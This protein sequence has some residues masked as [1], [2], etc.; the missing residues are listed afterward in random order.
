MPCLVSCKQ[1][2]A[3]FCWLLHATGGVEKKSTFCIAISSAF[4]KLYSSWAGLYN[5]WISSFT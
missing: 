3:P 4:T 1:P 5:M 2:L